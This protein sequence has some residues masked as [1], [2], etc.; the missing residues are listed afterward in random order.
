MKIME[1]F[2]E[3]QKNLRAAAPV[4]AFLGDSVTQG[5]FEVFFQADG[6]LDTVFE[7]ENS[8]P[9]ML[10]RK[11]T[12]LYPKVYPVIVNAGISGDSARYGFERMEQDIIRFKPDL[13]VVSYGLNESLGGDVD[14]YG[15][16]LTKIF[17]ALQAAGSEVI[18][19]TENMM[20]SRV[21]ESITDE[22]IIPIAKSFMEKQVAGVLDSFMERARQVAKECEVEVCDCHKIWRD[23]DRY[24]VDTTEL[25]S[26]KLNH[27]SRQMNMLFA[28]EL[29]K[30][31]LR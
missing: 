13:T 26:N 12:T 3:K 10:F 9:N 15:E 19:L 2:A 5:C 18:F 29:L 14:A 8:Y 24:G 25:L 17:K 23:M 1:K 11:L 30:T 4:I 16:N 27:P 22:R 21:H 28:E 6:S 20:N 7:P 31:M